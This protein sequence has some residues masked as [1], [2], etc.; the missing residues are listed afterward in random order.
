MAG[1]RLLILED[2]P[3]LLTVLAE[4][5]RREGLDVTVASTLAEA[6]TAVD[7]ADFDVVLADLRLPDGESL[8]LLR[9]Q[10]P[11]GG[12]GGG[13]GAVWVMMTAHATVG[14][15]VEALKLGAKDY[16]EKPFTLD[17]AVA[18]VRQ[19]LEMTALRREV[20]ALRDRS[21]HAG[22]MVIGESPPMKRVFEL[23]ER[24]AAVDATTVL[25]EGESGTGKG[26]IAQALHRLSKRSNGP[27]VNV[28]SSALP[29]TL[30]ESELFGHEKGAFTDAHAAK[31]GLVEMADGG[32][33]FLDEV[34]ELTP[35]V[36]SKL[37]RFIEEKTF[38]RLGGTR[39]LV[40]DVRIV[41]ATNRDLAGEV[42][43]GRFRADLFYRLRVIPITLPPLRERREDIAPLAKHFTAHFN[44]EFGKRVREIAPEAQAMLNAYAWPGNV[45]E[46]RNV[47]ERAVLLTDGEAIGT[48]ELAPEVAAPLAQPAGAGAGAGALPADGVKLDDVERRLLVEALDR[49]HGNQSQAAALLGLSRHQVRTRMRRHGLL[50]LALLAFAVIAPPRARAQGREPLRS[51]LACLR[52]HSSREFLE[53]A[54]PT[55]QF[56]SSLVVTRD[57]LQ[58]EASAHGSLACV[59]CHVGALTL[60]ARRR[61]RDAHRLH[62]L[63]RGDG[64]GPGRERA[65]T[66]SRGG[67]GGRL[68]HRLPRRAR[69]AHR[70]LA[71]E[72]RRPRRDQPGVRRL[73]PRAAPRRARRARAG[74]RM[75]R[76]PRRPRRP[77]RAGS[78]HAR[79]PGGDGP[80]LRGVPRRRGRVVLGRRPRSRRGARR[81][82][83]GRAGARHGGDLRGLP[84]RARGAE[85]GRQR[86][87]LRLRRNVHPLPS[88]VRRDLPGELSRSS[89]AGGLAA[90]GAVRELPHGP[91]RLSGVRSAQ[92][93]RRPRTG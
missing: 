66:G 35:G 93:G 70:G 21:S 3:L 8:A 23:V 34:G 51:S 30:M 1:E 52:C 63:S 74:G 37:L 18:T 27:F 55:G 48:R 41:A 87:P 9:E 77:P 59:A 67:G 82:Q 47:I 12:G 7:A 58:V 68:V 39:D 72:P 62:Q 43:A 91:R 81:G 60:P 73:S 65:R 25:I 10:A 19:A 69:R 53:R 42:A 2:D 64:F 16:L 46:L 61:R 45:R 90:G 11:R 56:R 44:R 80:A 92:L 89:D 4:R 26:A 24:L 13:G 38:R 5:M 20:A 36:Q 84:P 29:E 50:A 17:R 83:R 85:P 71:Q 88:R 54:V 31:R 75:H 14:S 76:L 15:A 33:L 32:T 86:R 79:R 28:T 49:A 78:R 57:S 40:V 6:R 22:T